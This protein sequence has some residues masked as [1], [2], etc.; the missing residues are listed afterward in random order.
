MRKLHARL[1]VTKLLAIASVTCLF[2]LNVNAQLLVDASGKTSLGDYSSSNDGTLNV[3]STANTLKAYYLTF[4][5]TRSHLCAL[6]IRNATH[7]TLPPNTIPNY[8]GIEVGCE[9]NANSSTHGISTCVSSEGTFNT[10]RAYGLLSEAGNSTSGWNF[11]ICTA[12]TGNNDGTGIYASAGGYPDGYNVQG[13][14][15][16]FFLGDVKV[17]GDIYAS[18]LI[19]PS[20]YRLKENIR[21]INDGTLDKIMGMNVVSYKLKNIEVDM[22]DTATKVYHAYPED[23]RIL[24]TDHYGLIA[25]E[26]REIYPDLVYEGS[27]GY[28]SVNYIEIIPLLIKSIQELRLQV[29]ELADSPEK[30]VLRNGGTTNTDDII[31]TAVLYQNNPNPFTENTSIKCVIPQDVAKADLYIYDMNGHQIESRNIG[32]RGNVSLLIEGN[33]LD[34]GM[35]LYSL[36]TDG[37]VVDTKRMIL[38]R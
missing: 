31:N 15:A 5:N 28:L 33:S 1:H 17:V 37:T 26:L 2:S 23:S 29:D 32:Q 22:G 3:T 36:I 38:T 9:N 13:R 16:G 24:K 7:A 12:V 27:D 4:L 21:H 20:D 30:A 11:G 6:G 18:T 14:W 19:T 8:F 35:Y 34:A 10:G 25:Q